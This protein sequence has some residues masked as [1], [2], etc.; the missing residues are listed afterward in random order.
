MNWKHLG[1]IAQGAVIGKLAEFGILCAIPMTDNMPFDI[2]AIANNKLFRIQVKGSSD[3]RR[4]GTYFKLSSSDWYTGKRTVYNIDMCDLIA[5][6]NYNTK[7]VYILEP[8]DFVNRSGITIRHEPPKQNQ[9]VN[10]NF[11]EDYILN[12][13]IVK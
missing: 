6:Y 10:C 7:D 3:T 1:D 5:C 12:E 9:K 13:N 8:K 4:G 11:K 2:I